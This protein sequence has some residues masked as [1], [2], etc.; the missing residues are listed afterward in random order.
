MTLD[1]TLVYFAEWVEQRKQRL[2]ATSDASVMSMQRVE[3]AGL[4]DFWRIGQHLC[5]RLAVGE[6]FADY[7]VA[8]GILDRPGS[9][10]GYA[11][12]P[13]HCGGVLV[14][15]ELI[16]RL[17][18]ACTVA[19]GTVSL[20]A[21]RNPDSAEH[22][23]EKAWRASGASTPEKSR[24]GELLA[25][26]GFAFLVHHELAH[27]G[28]GHECTR[29]R[30]AAET[31]DA[32]IRSDDDLPLVI[33]EC[34]NA[35]AAHED[36]SSGENQ[37]TLATEADADI[38][39]LAFTLQYVDELRMKLDAAGGADE[40]DV[41]W[42]RL[43]QQDSIRHRLVTLAVFVALFNLLVQPASFD[44]LKGRSHPPIPARMVVLSVAEAYFRKASIH[45][46]LLDVLT[47]GAVIFAARESSR[48]AALALAEAPTGVLFT[49]PSADTFESIWTDYGL[50]HLGQ[51]M[52]QIR[53]LYLG[54]A[55]VM[56]AQ[57]PRLKHYQRLPPERRIAWFEQS[58]TQ[59]GSHL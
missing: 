27:I 54:L 37:I 45:D 20:L 38:H 32:N 14:T 11:V 41:C 52:D 2:F 50:D 26:I 22:F 29:P 36:S 58:A 55:E 3:E 19:V 39:A 24:I 16:E 30:P 44:N 6:K 23:L 28:L 8:F 17:Q 34:A 12:W 43:L 5:S 47:T 21:S 56:R 25:H 46:A 35:A 1:G 51:R 7:P 13:A 48:R 9:S 31:A 15:K 40:F 10:N 4:G 57:E 42:L 53:D 33:D 59:A 18:G 49:L